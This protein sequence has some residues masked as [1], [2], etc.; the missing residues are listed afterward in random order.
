MAHHS[1]SRAGN[2]I[3]CRVPVRTTNKKKEPVQGHRPGSVQY[4]GSLLVPTTLNP[5]TTT[6]TI[7]ARHLYLIMDPIRPVRCV[8]SLKEQVGRSDKVRFTPVM[9]CI[10]H[11]FIK[12]AAVPAIP[13]LWSPLLPTHSVSH[14]AQPTL[15]EL[16]RASANTLCEP[17]SLVDIPA[18]C[19]QSNPSI[20][21]SQPP[22][23]PQSLHTPT[24]LPTNSP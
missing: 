1:P 5:T 8:R 6:H 24:Y 16:T 13:R 19:S 20:P 2:D 14:S 4:L 21:S 7:H 23:Q 3:R 10:G 15:V 11:A 9:H 22:P 17:H 12:A 18:P